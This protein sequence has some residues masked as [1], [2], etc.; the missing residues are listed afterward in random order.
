MKLSISAMR[1]SVSAVVV[2]AGST[3]AGCGFDPTS[4]PVPGST[5]SG[6]TYRVHIEFA[7]ALNLP[8]HAK[9]AANGRTVGSLDSVRVIDPAANHKGYVVADVDIS[10]GV[11][12]PASTTAQLRQSTVLGDIYIA[13]TTPADGFGTTIPGNGLIPLERTRPPLQIED[14]LSGLAT[15]VGGGAVTQFQEIVDRMNATLPAD[16]RETAGLSR[17]MGTDFTD[18]AT[19]LDRVSALGRTVAADVDSITQVRDDLAELLSKEGATQVTVATTSIAKMLGVLGAIGSITQ[20]IGWLAPIAAS[21]DA[22]AEAL[23]PL[24]FTARPLDLNAPSNL[25]RLVSVL[26][27]DLIPFVEQGPKVNIT[28]V[29]VTDAEPSPADDQVDRILATLRMIGAVR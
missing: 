21:G 8:A 4:I 19:N 10:E 6:P 18:L 20:G 2:I 17:L 24:L 7:T 27:D 13:L 16:P 23:V 12:L 26:R 15:F 28:G 5:V 1:L 29:H 25:N 22:A 3:V 14:L 9:V 11:R